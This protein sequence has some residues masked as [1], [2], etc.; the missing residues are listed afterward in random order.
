M[1]QGYWNPPNMER[2][3][4]LSRKEDNEIVSLH[5]DLDTVDSFSLPTRASRSL[6][7]LGV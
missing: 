2:A 7:S 6:S 4:F 3:S 1:Y 5:E